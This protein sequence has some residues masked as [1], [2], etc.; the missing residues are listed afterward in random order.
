MRNQQEILRAVQRT[1]DIESSFLNSSVRNIASA[2]VE[3]SARVK[4]GQKILISYEQDQIPLIKEVANRC[5]AKGASV[6]FFRNIGEEVAELLPTLTEEEIGQYC[7]EEKRLFDEA[8]FEIVINGSEKPEAFKKVPANLLTVYKKVRSQIRRG[9]EKYTIFLWP[10]VFEAKEEGLDYEEYFR[11]VIEASNQPWEKIENAQEIL[12]SKLSQGENLQILANKNDSD[13]RRKTDISMSIKGMTFV[14]STIRRNFPGSEVFSSPVI[15]SV[16][17]QIF[18]PGL[19]IYDSKRM[20]N[21]YLNVINGKVEEA[22][23]EEGNE[24]L[25]EILDRGEG[26]KRF[27]EVALGT[28]PGLTRRFL[29]PLYCEKVSGSFH[30]AL[31]YCPEYTSYF[32]QT[33]NVNNGNTRDRTPNHWDITVLMH[34]E[35]GGGGVILDGE[36][37]QENG[38]FLDPQLAILNLTVKRQDP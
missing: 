3:N 22:F 30:M 31:G 17:G 36:V 8:D 13:P 23:A 29:N 32:G 18:A 38:T 24:G 7:K 12:V 35:Q 5:V 28:N 19:F 33:V 9:K 25:Q 37:I 20:K 27:G 21:I 2:L 6:I 11:M 15:D 26:S 4:P 1:P 14:N 16:N 34:K 10:T